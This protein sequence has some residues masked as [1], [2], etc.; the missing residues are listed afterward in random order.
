MKRTIIFL[1]L[2]V[3][4]AAVLRLWNLGIVPPSP[5]WDEVSL[6]YNAYSIMHTGKDEY[7]QKLPIVLRSY[8]D[9]K[10]ALY[11]YF[12]IPFIKIFGL[13]VFAVRL[14]SAVFGI[15]TVLGTYFL[16]KEIFSQTERKLEIRNLKLG[17]PE[18]ASL[19][20]AVSPWHIQFSRIAFES[21][22]G[23]AFNI[24]FILLFLKGLKKPMY[25]LFAAFIMGVNLY[26]YQSEKVF[27]PL[28]FATLVALFRKQLFVLP[29]KYLILA[30]VIGAVISYPL[31]SYTIT[32]NEALARA[33]GVSIFSEQT[34]LLKESS[35][36]LAESREKNEIFGLIFNNRRIVYAKEVVAGYL[37][38][39]NLNWLFI[40][41]DIARHHAPYMGLLYLWELPF[42]LIGMYGLIVGN[43]DRRIKLLVFSW[44]LIAPIPAS[45]TSGVPHAVR[46]LNFLPIFQ[47]FTAVGIISALAY[48]SSIKY[49]L[50]NMKL[51]YI[52]VTC[53]LL[54]V[55][56][57][58]I[59]YLNQYFV[60]QNY[61]TSQD[62][63]YGYKEAIEE[64]QRIDNK[65]Q[66]I[67]VS[68]KFP[69]ANINYLKFFKICICK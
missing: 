8:D 57:N 54:L 11:A 15:L 36:R 26:I 60:Q 53:C 27:T 47:I 18:V 55:T 51:S 42:L 67:I 41:G 49:K 46:T 25:L 29:K 16:L 17:I 61:F 62:W 68:K 14:P 7:G 40:T 34:Q 37:S 65:Y 6:G 3:A 44:F 33:K 2:I 50:L 63:Q 4:I 19:L 58:F 28:L 1:I 10:P 20:L 32:N 45:I 12:V 43:F 52:L 39:Y 64:V 22:V 5:N 24:F 30:F 35:L 23:L 56:F 69:A 48:A 38:H 13:Q 9:Y 66:K 59:Y 31:A 21:N